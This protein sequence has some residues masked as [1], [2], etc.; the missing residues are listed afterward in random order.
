MAMDSFVCCSRPC[1]MSMTRMAMSHR[2][3]PRDRRLVNDSCPGV[4]MMSRPGMGPGP[5]PEGIAQGISNGH[6]GAWD[7]WDIWVPVY[8]AGYPLS[9]PPEASNAI[10]FGSCLGLKTECYEIGA[11]P[12]LSSYG[13]IPPLREYCCIPLSFEQFKKV[14]CP[15]TQIFQK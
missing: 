3:D 1:M 7:L 13:A 9:N 12:F 14:I 2:L 5:R 8:S 6:M 4:S 15:V 11:I 10:L